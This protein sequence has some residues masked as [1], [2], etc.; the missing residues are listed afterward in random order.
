MDWMSSRSK[1]V[2][3]LWFRAS[4]TSRVIRSPSCSIAF[5]SSTLIRRSSK[6]EV[7]AISAK[8]FTAFSRLAVSRARISWNLLLLR[9]ERLDD[10]VELLQPGASPPRDGRVA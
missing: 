10:A 5:S 9:Q 6:L 1:G 3:K 4:K 7:R 2:M 8:S